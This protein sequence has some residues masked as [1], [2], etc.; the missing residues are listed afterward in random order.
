MWYLPTTVTLIL[1]KSLVLK[2]LGVDGL[3]S[4]KRSFPVLPLLLLLHPTRTTSVVILGAVVGLSAALATRAPTSG[5]VAAPGW[6]VANPRRFECRCALTSNVVATR[7]EGSI[8]L[9]MHRSHMTGSVERVGLFR[10]GM[11]GW[12]VKTTRLYR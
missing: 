10:A 5:V 6:T 8:I 3:N 11:A 4:Y 12:G 9:R 1:P 7:Q 2:E